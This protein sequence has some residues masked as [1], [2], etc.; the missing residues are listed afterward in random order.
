MNA[1]LYSVVEIYND[2]HGFYPYRIKIDRFNAT[3]YPLAD[4][5]FCRSEG[6]KALIQ[7]RRV[8]GNVCPSP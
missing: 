1:V 7:Q 2:Y 6:K 5:E 8:C 3:F 4:V